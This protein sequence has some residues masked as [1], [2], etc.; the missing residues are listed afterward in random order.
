[1]SAAPPPRADRRLVVLGLLA[2]GLA[3]VFTA[4][5]GLPPR[6]VGDGSE[7]Y[8]L[9]LSWE[10]SLRPWMTQAAYVAYDELF[11][12]HEIMDL[13][14]R[15]ALAAAFP[16][17]RVGDTA[18]FNHFW[19]YSLLAR[20][21]GATLAAVGLHVSAHGAF[22]ALHGLMLFMTMALAHRHYGLRGLC[23]V[24]FMT[25][26]SPMIWF[27]NKVHTEFF[28]YCLTLSSVILVLAGR[29]VAAAVLLGLAATQNPSF[30]IVAAALV[31]DRLRNFRQLPSAAEAAGIVLAGLLSVMHPLYYLWRVHVVTP[32]LLAGGASLGH[33]LSTFYIWF[34]DPDV[35][36]LPNWPLGAL[37]IVLGMWALARLPEK[38]DPSRYNGSWWW[39]VAVY[40]ASC[41]YAHSST[42]N[43]NSGATPGLARYALWYMVLPFPLYL[44][45][46]DW[47]RSNWKR[48][49]AG[50]VLLLLL[51][52][53]NWRVCKPQLPES[54]AKPS[55]LSRIIQTKMPWLYDPPGEIFRER[56]SGLGEAA[57]AKASQG[58]VGP[59]CRK[60]LLQPNEHHGP[61]IAPQ[62]CGF[63]QQL[64]DAHVRARLQ[65][66][67]D[68]RY[69]RIDDELYLK[70]KGQASHP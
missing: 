66:R 53:H 2:L 7:Y 45:A 9:Y 4:L 5:A 8:A 10:H 42:I 55:K 46:L 54:Y 15:D 28:T 1:M 43:L 20:M 60:L 23:V 48:T 40:L 62:A 58:I 51:L 57:E 36:L 38:R 18:D 52:P 44:E 6:R 59:D 26:A 50:V 69:E 14:S 64:L 16:A 13:V 11:S 29:R 49:G 22:I 34:L 31:A 19:L 41:L 61:A 70:L 24:A 21:V 25:F 33:N 67:S 47:L 3:F 27:T 56:Y 37:G 68:E 17:L 30:A 65:Q 32:Q 12:R 35:G 39:F 63:D